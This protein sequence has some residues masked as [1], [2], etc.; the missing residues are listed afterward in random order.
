MNTHLCVL[1][2]ED[3]PVQM[4]LEEGLLSPYYQV[5]KAYNGEEAIAAFTQCQPHLILMDKRLPGMDG[6]QLCNTLRKHATGWM[7]PILF[8]SAEITLE[9]RL[10]AYGA[11]GEDFISKPFAP[12]ELLVK[13]DVAL[14][15]VAERQRLEGSAKSAFNTAMTAM[16]TASEIG[17]VLNAMRNS[18]TAENITQVCQCLI[19]ACSSYQI[20]AV[21]QIR[22]ARELVTLNQNG[23]ASVLEVETLS[24]LAGRGRIISAHGHAAFNFGNVTLLVGDLPAADTERTGRMRDNLAMVAEAINMRVTA[25]EN[26]TALH[27]QYQ[28]TLNLFAH[29]TTALQKV[30]E[31]F[32]QQFVE[33]RIAL[34][35]MIDDTE[36]GIFRLGLTNNQEMLLSQQLR[37][38]ENKLLTIYDRG[39][40]IEDHL[41]TL[42]EL[43]EKRIN[44][45]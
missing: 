20:K 25:L 28:H 36:N 12:A 35:S 11:G 18:F 42:K 37:I 30:D 8:V 7:P 45:A 39:L 13:I 4:L 44:Q 43:M 19:D 10:E 17:V 21:A 32:R 22:G 34:S 3:E 6:V 41:T 29:A 31:N 40:A 24:V 1:I 14:R 15:N 26:E 27:H 16:S 9:D 5:M 2:V 38:T 33:V 23:V